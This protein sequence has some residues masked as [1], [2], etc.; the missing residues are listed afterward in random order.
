MTRVARYMLYGCPSCGAV[1]KHPLWGSISVHVPRSINP[2]L[3]R[4]CVKC[5][6]Q[7]NLD[8][9]SAL[10]AVERFTPEEQARRSAYWLPGTEPPP[11][12]RTALQK[13]KEF[14]FGR[15]PPVDL[16]EKY[17]LISIVVEV[18]SK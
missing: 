1:Y 13:V 15:P 11:D 7:A 9:W 17:P 14:L 2:N 8:G 16:S 10:G 12:T 5:G 6:F 18:A 3:D 4:I